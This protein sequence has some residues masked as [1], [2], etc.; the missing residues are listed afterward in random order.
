[1]TNEV[2]GACSVLEIF[3]LLL[4]DLFTVFIICIT[5]ILIDPI[6]SGLLILFILIFTLVFYGTFKSFYL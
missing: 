5:L 2:H 3:V 1:M 4:R 6:I